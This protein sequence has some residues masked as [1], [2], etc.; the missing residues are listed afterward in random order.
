MSSSPEMNS[1]ARPRVVLLFG[2]RSDEHEISCVTAAGVAAAVDATQFEVIAVGVT[3]EGD[4]VLAEDQID[5]FQLDASAM[6]E[7]RDNGT[8]VLWPTSPAHPALR[9]VDAEGVQHNLGTI[10]VVFPVLHGPFGE[11]GTLQGMLEMLSLPYVGS[12]VLA[13]ALGM[14]K[15]FA[16]S[17][18]EAAGLAVA[19]WRRITEAEYAADPSVAQRAAAELG[20]PV[21][22]KPARAGSSVGVS[23]VHAEVDLERAMA[24]AFETDSEVLLEPTIVGREIELAVLGQA[25]GSARVSDVAGE[26]VVSGREFYDYDAKYLDAAGVSLELPATVTERELGELQTLALRAFHA[27]GCADLARVDFFLTDNGAIINEVNTMP[28]FTPISM[29]PSLWIASGVSYADLVGSLIRLAIT[30]GTAR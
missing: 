17:V 7:V 8:R 30:R 18:L 5:G 11:D 14:H 23:K 12:G 29:Y 25:D 2:G 16:K 1:A 13:S 3:R 27:L 9:F 20:Y 15:H 24:S 10:D 4:Y 19:P 22:V 6:P 26:I 21:F 28:G